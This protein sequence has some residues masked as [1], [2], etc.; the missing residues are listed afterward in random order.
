M[1]ASRPRQ[2]G[3]GILRYNVSGNALPGPRIEL[4]GMTTLQHAGSL[5]ALGILLSAGAVPT[6]AVAAGQEPSPQAV[7]ELV[8]RAIA[9]QHR[10]DAA[11]T[12]YERREHRQARKEETDTA[13]SE[14]KTF[15]VVPT[16]TG[17]LRLLIEEASQPVP[18]EFYRR[19][20]RDLEQGLVW[21]LDPAESKQKRRIEKFN[22]RNRERAEMVD[23]IGDAFLFT[24]QGR[25]SSN[26]HFPVRILLEPDPAYRPR[27]RNG[28]IFRRVRAVVW[29]DEAS[30]QLVRIE[31]E[32]ISDISFGGGVLGKIYRGGRLVLEQAQ[33]AEGVWFPTRYEY[34]F[35][36]RK[37]VFGFELHEVT[38]ASAYR[39]IGPPKE[40]LA[41]IR[42]ELSN[43]TPAT[44]SH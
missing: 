43:G 19:Q 35:T 40:A 7:R 32:I 39:R 36:G 5:F 24:W 23:A 11:L 13:L 3:V 1:S 28:E 31:A 22:K 42:R 15:R 41:A 6:A 4:L 9:N 8:E 37:F 16:G 12:E 21:A 26:G 18:Q 27:S 29:I 30:T 10:N 2:S 20:L 17:T 34:H 38:L 33:V 25:E 44:G 14:D